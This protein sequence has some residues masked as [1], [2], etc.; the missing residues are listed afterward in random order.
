MSNA[1]EEGNEGE[2]SDCVCEFF[3]QMHFRAKFI[4]FL[5]KGQKD[6]IKV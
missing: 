4:V 2:I 6:Y 5:Y 1:Y 3:Y